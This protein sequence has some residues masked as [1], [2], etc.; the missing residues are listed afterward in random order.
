M[1]VFSLYYLTIVT[2]PACM[3]RVVKAACPLEVK[4]SDFSVFHKAQGRKFMQTCT[5]RNSSF[6]SMLVKIDFIQACNKT[7]AN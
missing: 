4:K 6:Q 3:V 7:K 5:D 2:Y 1:V